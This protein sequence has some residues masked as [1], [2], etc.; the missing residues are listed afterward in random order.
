[1]TI[2]EDGVIQ[3][4]TQKKESSESPCCSECGEDTNVLYLHSEC[5]PDSPTWTRVELAENGELERIIVACAE[6]ERHI[7]T[8]EINDQT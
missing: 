1:M 3:F 6:C 7:F 4:P 8:Y 5:H 2:E